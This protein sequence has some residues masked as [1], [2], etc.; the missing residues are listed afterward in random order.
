MLHENPWENYNASKKQL[1][2]RH[3]VY[4]FYILIII[5]TYLFI[6]FNVYGFA[7]YLY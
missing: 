2:L 6:M 4:K 5:E 3:I 7:C 1:Q